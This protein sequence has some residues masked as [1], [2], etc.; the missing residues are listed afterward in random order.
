[1]RTWATDLG[2]PCHQFP[3][4]TN[5]LNHDCPRTRGARPRF[6]ILTLT[7]LRNKSGSEALL[8]RA[9]SPKWGVSSLSVGPLDSSL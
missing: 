9:G 1:M 4:R 2:A 7:L 5:E 8:P 3:L 6:V